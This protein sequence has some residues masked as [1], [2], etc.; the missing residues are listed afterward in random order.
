MKTWQEI[1]DEYAKSFG[2]EYWDDLMYDCASDYFDDP[3]NTLNSHIDAVSLLR[4]KESLDNAE[5]SAERA[6]RKERSL[7]RIY[8]KM[9]EAIKDENNI[10]L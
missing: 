10:P 7:S 8:L 4:A 2:Y 9:Y 1:K 6:A 3:H 5:S